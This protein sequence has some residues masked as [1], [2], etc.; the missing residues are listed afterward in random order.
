MAGFTD[1]AMRIVCREWGADLTFTEMVS[2]KAVRYG[3]KKTFTLSRID[4][5]EGDCILQL[6]G[7]E[8]DTLAFATETLLSTAEIKPVGIDINMGC[9]VH[10]IFSNGEG[11]ALMKKPSLIYEIVKATREA[12]DLPLSVK[13]RLGVDDAHKN[14]VE[15]ALAA[16]SAGADFITVHGR[17]RAQMYGGKSDLESIAEVKRALHIP[18]IASGDVVDG[19]SALRTLET[20]KADAIMIGRAAIGNPFV[21]AEIK[22]AL[23]GTP[24]REITLEMKMATALRQLSL[25]IELKGEHTAVLESRKQ[26]AIYFKGR[27]GASALRGAL[28]TATTYDEIKNL[29]SALG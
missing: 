10:K 9:P 11:S 21:F 14:A 18:L 22:S 2:A 1:S 12:T 24:P 27:T 3:D 8:P 16:E 7:N 19:E 15:C 29:L 5:R 13:M 23:E 6:F 28:N 17:T 20:T 4:E 25:A 26:L